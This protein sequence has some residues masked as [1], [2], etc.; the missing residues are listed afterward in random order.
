MGGAMTLLS[1]GEI[2]KNSHNY[3]LTKF[4]GEDLL[5]FWPDVS[6]M[7]DKIPHTLGYLTK[8]E[9][10]GAL[11]AGNMGLWGMGPAPSA[12]F[13]FITAILFYPSKNVLTVGWG[14]GTF[15]KDMLPILDATLTNYA[16][17]FD[18]VAIE[19]HGRHGWTR[20]LEK[21]GFKETRVV[22]ARPVQDL[23]KH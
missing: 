2:S 9:I 22:L 5:K 7:M 6:R 14:A 18:C 21:I 15:K 19:I 17:M 8:D 23:R 4:E 16:R 20:A 11:M 1:A 3:A 10:E 12:I 13:V